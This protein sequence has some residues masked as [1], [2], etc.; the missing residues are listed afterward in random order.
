MIQKPM[1][2]NAAAT[3]TAPRPYASIPRAPGVPLLGSIPALWRRDFAF[4][5]RAHAQCGDLFVLDLGV[6]EMLFVAEPDAAEQVLVQRSKN[7][8]KSDDF[9]EGAR[10]TVGNGLALSEG[11]LWR[12]QRRLMNPAFRRE[13]IAEFQATIEATVDELLAELT[14]LA[15]TGQ[16]FD[17]SLWTSN[18]LSTLTV[19]LLIGATLGP[20]DFAKFRD[21]L[22]IVIRGVF[23]GVVTRKLPS[24][25]PL[26][27]AS[28]FEQARRDI[29]Q[30]ILR[31]IAERRATPEAGNDLLGM[32]IAATDE[33]GTMSDQQLRD[34]V[35]ITYVAGYE[36]T[37]WALA[38]GLV[39]LAEHPTQLAE[40]QAALDSQADPMASPL[41]DATVREI[42]R[43][44][45][46]APFI[47]RRAV[48]DEE[49]CGHRV[50]AGT[51]V[52]VS[53]WLI[54]RNP[55]CWSNP[56]RFDP[57]RHI[58]ASTRPRL[59]WMPFGAGQRLCIGQ[60]LAMMEASTTLARLL[61]R[62]TLM[63]A[64]GHERSEPIVSAT[65]SSRDGIWLR[66]QPRA[67]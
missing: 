51:M 58:D 6:T 11:E 47:P 15:A 35:I 3:T 65:L 28:R 59:A 45:P 34:E 17:V 43:L 60:G 29:N 53:P 41:L 10:E 55:R 21:A 67:M 2:P 50:P 36:T 40:L 5:E 39:L 20:K 30:I 19:R 54:H 16:T 4:F 8:D 37:A 48:V 44:Y 46:S 38:W 22:Q 24:W 66:L 64:Q 33:E 13:R 57:R 32:L 18:L 31:I 1:D 42:L 56:S 12:R 62:F 27:G 61:R 26:P 14:P 25:V 23:S 9:F 49:L 63:P 52:V 7:F